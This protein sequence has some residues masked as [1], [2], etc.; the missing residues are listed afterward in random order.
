[1]YPLCNTCGRHHPP[2]GEK[3]LEPIQG[4]Y[5]LKPHNYI[6]LACRKC[7]EPVYREKHIEEPVCYECKQVRFRKYIMHYPRQYKWK[8]NNGQH[9]TR[10]VS[11]RFISENATRSVLDVEHLHQTVPIFGDAH[12]QQQ[13][14][15]KRTVSGYV[16]RA[17]TSGSIKKIQSTV[18]LC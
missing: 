3:F 8:G 2:D 10:I 1:M 9:T 4:D 15:Q 11:F 12:I 18:S 5:R 13:D 14:F 17:M 6:K 7:G 16:G